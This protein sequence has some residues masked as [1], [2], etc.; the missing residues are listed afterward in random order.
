MRGCASSSAGAA[1]TLI[2]V[3]IF[4]HFNPAPTTQEGPLLLR[5]WHYEEDDDAA[6]A[7]VTPP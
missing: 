5:G 2:F 4:L 7:V 3:S 6:A 1:A